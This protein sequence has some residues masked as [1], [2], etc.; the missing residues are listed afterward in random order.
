MELLRLMEFKKMFEGALINLGNKKDIVNKL[1]VFPVPDGDT[2]TNMFLTLKTAMDETKKH[3][4][5]DLKEFGKAIC[6]GAL[7]GGRGNSGVILSQI[8]KGFFDYIDGKEE[9][10]IPEFS[11]ALLN[12]SK[13]AYK[14]VIKPVE[15][16]ILTVMSA[17]AKKAIVLSRNETSFKNLIKELLKES[18]IV[19]ENTPELL[20]VLKEAGVVDSGG[21]GLVF[22]TEG[23]LMGLEGNIKIE[24]TFEEEIEE[25]DRTA[26]GGKLEFKYDT[27]LL[28]VSSTI[29]PEQLQNDLRQFGD[30]IVVAKTGNLTKVH[31]HSNEPYKVMEFVMKYGE[32]REARIENMQEEQEAFLKM[33]TP[34][35]PGTTGIKKPFCIISVS[36][37]EGFD[38]IFA[39]IGVDVIVSGGQTMNPSINDIL[40][41]VAKCKKDKVII[42]PNNSNI[43]L[44][45]KEAAKLSKGKK[46]VVLPTKNMVQA[47]PIV[48]S[49]NAEEEF[50]KNIER[51]NEM[52]KE[53]HSF[54][55]TYSVRDTVLKGMKLK[56]GDIL[57]AADGEIVL[58]GNDPDNVLTELFKKYK[59]TIEDYEVV[60][61][62]YGRGVKKERAEKLGEQIEKMFS[63]IE[64]DVSYGG[65]PF[66]FYLI[67]IE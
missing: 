64:V 65:Q 12:G 50:G 18:Q 23:M 29:I 14:A 6:E 49:F 16:T 39:S 40:S 25:M 26:L 19:L 4:P 7:I 60:G 44:A 24:K 48:L 2:G 8:F 1:N 53:I 47:I 33:A 13:T 56:K 17:I 20:P 45:A 59:K 36:Q 46:V 54:A 42:F 63:D 27:V 30:S 57:G 35:A 41:A 11:E 58:K 66:Y 67:S 62:Y 32:L 10:S 3:N 15:G 21:Q 28:I 34:S 22:I 38:D 61:I 43:I 37:G 55:V 5:A 31:V 51:A 9:V 52:L